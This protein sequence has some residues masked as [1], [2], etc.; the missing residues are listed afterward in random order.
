SHFAGFIASPILPAT[1][2]FTQFGVKMVEGTPWPWR[3]EQTRVRVLG[4]LDE[5]G[6]AAQLLLAQYV[7][8]FL[9]REARLVGG[10]YIKMVEQENARHAQAPGKHKV[11][12]VGW[13]KAAERLG[14]RPTASHSGETAGTAAAVRMLFRC[15]SAARKHGR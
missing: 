11:G 15:F 2:P 5:T 14:I 13:L 4:Q 10:P 1:M 6:S 7:G 3:W 12:W 8:Q 9:Y